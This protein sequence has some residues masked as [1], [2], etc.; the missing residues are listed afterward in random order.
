MLIPLL[1]IVFLPVP[2][3]PQR[4]METLVNI[5]DASVASGPDDT[6]DKLL[7]LAVVVVDKDGELRSI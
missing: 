5:L 6:K 7:G 3:K 2:T 4:D 1:P